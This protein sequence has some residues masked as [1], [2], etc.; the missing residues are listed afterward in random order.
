M[1]N[2]N[3]NHKCIFNYT[4]PDVHIASF[5]CE[6]LHQTVSLKVILGPNKI[7]N[8]K[9]VLFIFANNM[10]SLTI[11]LHVFAFSFLKITLEV[12]LIGFYSA[13]YICYI[14]KLTCYSF[15][16]KWLLILYSQLIPIFPFL[17]FICSCN[18]CSI[19]YQCLSQC[20]LC[21]NY[22]NQHL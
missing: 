11:P 13:K 21:L 19:H 18:L 22:G 6:I 8:M 9:N 7:M 15:K 3:K 12:H 17:T 10:L 14:F 2:L 1:V 4:H 20:K 16:T 5:Q